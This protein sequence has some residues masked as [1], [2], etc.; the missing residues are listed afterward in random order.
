MGIMSY[1]LPADFPYIIVV[2]VFMRPYATH[3]N[4]NDNTVSFYTK[5]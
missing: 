4:R 1:D 5:N 3:F 2:D